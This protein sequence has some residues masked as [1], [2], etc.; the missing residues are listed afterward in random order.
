MTYASRSF[1]RIHTQ[2]LQLNILLVLEKSRRKVYS[3]PI[4]D[5]QPISIKNNESYKGI[6]ITKDLTQTQRK[7]YEELAQVAKIKN[8]GEVDKIL[9]VRRNSKNGFHLKKFAKTN[10]LEQVLPQEP[11]I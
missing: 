5:G 1:C 2:K 10:Y 9:L 4:P 6:S 3:N 7:A 11:S 8:Q